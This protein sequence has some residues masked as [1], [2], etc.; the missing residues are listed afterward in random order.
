VT[1]EGAI[2]LEFHVRVMSQHRSDELIVAFDIDSIITV[3]GAVY[4]V[5]HIPKENGQINPITI[6]I[7]TPSFHHEAGLLRS[8]FRTFCQD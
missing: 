2:L 5:S 1:T 3:H 7:Q 8:S 6:H 4:P